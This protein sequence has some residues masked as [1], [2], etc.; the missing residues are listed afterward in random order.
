MRGRKNRVLFTLLVTLLFTSCSRVPSISTNITPTG[1]VETARAATQTEVPK[2]P[3][4]QYDAYVVD[5][6][7]TNRGCELPCWWGAVPGKSEWSN[8]EKF[9][10]SFVEIGYGGSGIVKKG[11][12]DVFIENTGANFFVP[13]HYSNGVV[14]YQVVDGIIQNIS[15]GNRGTEMRYRIG[16]LL[17]LLGSPDN[18]F[19]YIQAP[20][21]DHVMQFDLLL[22]YPD[23]GIRAVYEWTEEYATADG[24]V[25]VCPGKIGPELTLF[26]SDTVTA[27]A[28]MR[29]GWDASFP[30][31]FLTLETAAG[32]R[33]EDFVRKI[34][35]NKDFCFHSPSDLWKNDQ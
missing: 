34:K 30:D 1:Q 27:E 29:Y 21:P 8:E 12:K 3:Q 24:M 7:L 17:A 2:V 33:N 16:P 6:L 19:V 15:V 11:D 32:L 10:A 26:P 28:I 13:G 9:L 35:E 31:A 22:I 18:V 4:E 23:K 20:T 14:G 5:L 25:E